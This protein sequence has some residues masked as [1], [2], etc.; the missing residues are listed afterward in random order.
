M[1]LEWWMA[2]VYVLAV[3]VLTAGA[4]WIIRPWVGRIF[5]EG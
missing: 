5:P 4:Y 2:P 1:Q 3:A